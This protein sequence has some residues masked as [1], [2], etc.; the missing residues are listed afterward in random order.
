MDNASATNFL[1]PSKV[2][3]KDLIC[4]VTNLLTLRYICL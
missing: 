1:I 2:T 4:Q 3:K